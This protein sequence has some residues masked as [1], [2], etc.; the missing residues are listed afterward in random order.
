VPASQTHRRRSKSARGRARFG[1]APR[2]PSESAD[3]DAS[4]TSI[5]R[6]FARVKARTL[7]K[8]CGEGELMFGDFESRSSSGR[9]EKTSE[10][11]KP[12]VHN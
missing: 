4:S 12:D 6:R 3:P 10:F 1:T 8:G 5:R 7:R 9:D 2:Q 11:A